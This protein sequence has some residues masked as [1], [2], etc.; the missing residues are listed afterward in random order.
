MKTWV[1]IIRETVDAIR[2]N[3]VVTLR[4]LFPPGTGLLKATTDDI[5]LVPE[6]S[7]GGV[8]GGEKI[9]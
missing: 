2:I 6:S 8:G 4:R 7:V 9:E 1:H 5:V 3:D